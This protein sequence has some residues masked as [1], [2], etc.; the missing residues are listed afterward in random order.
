MIRPCLRS[1]NRLVSPEVVRRPRTTLSH[2]RGIRCS[3]STR[4]S[5][6]PLFRSKSRQRPSIQMRHRMDAMVAPMGLL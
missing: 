5:L 6:D 1:R 4:T 2:P 3:T